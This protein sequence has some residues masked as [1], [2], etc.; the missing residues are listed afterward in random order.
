[1]MEFCYLAQAV[2][3]P[4]DFWALNRLEAT[5]KVVNDLSVKPVPT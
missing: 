1:M 5:G 4:G 2:L 3:K